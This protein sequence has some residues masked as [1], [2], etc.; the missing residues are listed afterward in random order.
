MLKFLYRHLR[1]II[2]PAIGAG[3]VVYFAYHTVQGERGL[4]AWMKLKVEIAE[5]EQHLIQVSAERQ[6]L[7][8]RVNLLHPEHLD[9]DLLEERARA[10]LNMGHEGEIIIVERP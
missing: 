9:P 3:A 2:A 4:L 10:M 6:A 5:A 7:E 1:S 8:R